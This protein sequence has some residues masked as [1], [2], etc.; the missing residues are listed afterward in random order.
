MLKLFLQTPSFLFGS[1]ALLKLI[2]CV[3]LPLNVRR[4]TVLEFH[5]NKCAG[6]MLIFEHPSLV[7]APVFEHDLFL[8]AQKLK[9]EVK[10]NWVKVQLL[11]DRFPWRRKCFQMQL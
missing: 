4:K 3:V 8:Q 6:K 5:R 11:K 9:R 7:K 2:R 10:S 1:V